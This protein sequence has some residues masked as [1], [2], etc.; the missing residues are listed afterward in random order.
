MAD[1]Q[2]PAAPGEGPESTGQPAYG[3]P[4]PALIARA[5]NGLAHFLAHTCD[6]DMEETDQ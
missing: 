3:V 6:D 1:I 5:A 4:S 2:D